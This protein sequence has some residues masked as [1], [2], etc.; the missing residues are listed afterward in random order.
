MTASA[1]ER[2][3]GEGEETAMH[4]VKRFLPVRLEEHWNN[5]A[6]S[7]A[8]E[9]GAGRFNVWRNSFP[10]EHLPAPGGELVVGDV[11]YRFPKTTADGDNIRC[12]GQYLRLSEGRYDW[13]HLL[14]SGERRVETELALHFANGEVDFEAVRVSDFWAASAQFGEQEAARTPVMHYPHHVQ[15]GVPAML[16]S[17]RVPVTRTAV[18]RGI[19]LPQHIALHVLALTLES[20]SPAP[21]DGDR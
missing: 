4:A 6:V 3:A 19:R 16:W 13:I 14:A 11:P 17:Q 15:R 7:A 2:P 12:A 5:R 8:G 18:L 1:I 20:V 9:T 21:L 10:A